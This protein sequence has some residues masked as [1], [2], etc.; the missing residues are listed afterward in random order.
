MTDTPI[1]LS[2]SEIQAYKSCRRRWWLQYFRELTPKDVTG[3]FVGPL[4]LGSRVHAALE[5]KYAN[6][7]DPVSVYKEL[8]EEDRIRFEET[9]AAAFADA[10]ERFYI[11]GDLGRIMLSGLESWL[12]EEGADTDYAIIAAESEM[13]YPLFGGRV[14]LSA[15][16]DLLIEDLRTGTLRIGDIKTAVQ[17]KP[18]HDMINMS[19]QLMLYCC[20][21]KLTQELNVSGGSYLVLKKVKRSTK[22]KP[23]YY[24]LIEVDY[25]QKTLDN[26]WNRVMAESSEILSVRDRLDAGESH[27]TACYPSPGPDCSW[28]CPFFNGCYMFDDGSDAERWLSDNFVQHDPY[29]RYQTEPT[30]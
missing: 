18:Y 16:A 12:V 4:S 23:P 14:L 8:F 22:S 26:F 15:K 24:E 2:N 6:H 20:L 5:A 27:Q 30:T 13:V 7:A 1:R 3:S 11:E 19:E 28:K 25:S 10:S 17:I 9:D 21:A 29:A